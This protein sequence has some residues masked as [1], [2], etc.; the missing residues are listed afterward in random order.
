M[1]LNL[2]IQRGFVP[3]PFTVILA[4]TGYMTSLNFDDPLYVIRNPVLWKKGFT[5][6]GE[7]GRF[8]DEMKEETGI[9]CTLVLAHLDCG[10]CSG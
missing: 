8:T 10:R 7:M 6:R 5:P 9:P 4:V 2:G 3:F 1:R